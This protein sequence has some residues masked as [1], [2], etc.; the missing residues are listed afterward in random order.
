MVCVL[1]YFLYVGGGVSGGARAPLLYGSDGFNWNF[2]IFTYGSLENRRSTGVKNNNYPYSYGRVQGQQHNTTTPRPRTKQREKKIYCSLQYEW[3]KQKNPSVFSGRINCYI[4]TNK[5]H[6][7]TSY[8]D[9]HIYAENTFHSVFA[10]HLR[11]YF[12][13]D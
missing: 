2:F 6:T 13:Y 9:M 4:L 8:T 3:Y 5:I 11:D 10:T 1:Q 7:F 12:G